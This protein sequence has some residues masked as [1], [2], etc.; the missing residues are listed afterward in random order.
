VGTLS[1]RAFVNIPIEILS[2]KDDHA[3]R[4][5][6]QK[7]DFVFEALSEREKIERKLK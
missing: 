3:N 6:L 5:S 2:G 1:C 4:L 7:N